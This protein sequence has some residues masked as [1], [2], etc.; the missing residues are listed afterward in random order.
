MVAAMTLCFEQP[1]P[2]FYVF[3]TVTFV[4]RVQKTHFGEGYTCKYILF[5]NAFY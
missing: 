5:L 2:I 3:F 1:S 4:H